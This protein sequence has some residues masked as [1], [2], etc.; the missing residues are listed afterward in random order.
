LPV[1]GHDLGSNV[2]KRSLLFWDHFPRAFMA[3]N[4]DEAMYPVCRVPFRH[5][6]PTLICSLFTIQFT[7]FAVKREWLWG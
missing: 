5:G 1:V 7:A 2:D 6:I 4:Q 3:M